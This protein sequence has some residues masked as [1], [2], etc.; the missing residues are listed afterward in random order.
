ML[1][2]FSFLLA[3][4]SVQAA[5]IINHNHTDITA[6]PLEAVEQARRNLHI[7]YGHTSHGSQL[8]TGMTGLVQ[9]AN[10]GGLG[11]SVPQDIFAWNNGGIGGALDLH[12]IFYGGDAGSYP[13]WFEATREY[14]DNPDNSDV[15]VIIW[16]WCGQV[17]DKYI[18]GT[19]MSEYLQPMTQL[20]N[21]YPHVQFVYMTGHVDIDEDAVNKAANEM[22]RQ[23]VREY[24]KILYDFADI[25][26]YDP[27]GRYYPY[28]NDNCEYFDSTLWPP[29]GNW[30]LEWQNSHVEGV[31]WYDCESAH[32]EPLNANRKAYA[33]WYLWTVLAGWQASSEAAVNLEQSSGGTVVSEGGAGD[34][35]SVALATEPTADVNISVMPD[36][37]ISVGGGP[38]EHL[39]LQFTPN[40]WAVPQRVD[41]AAVDDVQP[42]CAH[43]GVIRHAVES[44]DSEYDNI[45][46]DSVTV[47]ISDNEGDCNLNPSVNLLL[48]QGEGSN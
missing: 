15:N 34:S 36:E 23:Y 6:L 37:Q 35:Y 32:S 24:D 14:L 12:E 3:F 8:T 10:N 28:V 33:A 47:R 1:S 27:D 18:D 31:D 11:L 26:R 40:N 43:T 41:V 39:V 38:G 16:A 46:V 9:F 13:S 25:E 30:A 45:V 44:D 5:T 48:L 17:E 2:V 4:S 19:L 7:V 22:I 20:E 29:Q 21:E 42:E